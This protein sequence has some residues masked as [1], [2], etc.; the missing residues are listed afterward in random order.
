MTRLIIFDLDGTLLDTIAD[1]GEACNYA[2]RQHGFPTHDGAKYPKMVGN[3]VNKLLERALPEGHKDMETVLDLKTD[4]IAY[5]NDH[6]RVHTHP[7]PGIPELLAE[8][9]RRDILLAVASNKYQEA[10]Q[11]LIRHYFGDGFFDV[12]LG[13]RQG[14]ERKPDPQIV[15]DIFAALEGRGITTE[16][17]LYV[18]DSDVDMQTAKNAHL[19]SVGCTW[20]FCTREKLQE[21]QP[22][23]LV[24]EPSEITK[25]LQ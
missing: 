20:G 24:D 12:V 1:L 21:N 17:T 3:G 7:Y 25:L 2:L 23:H 8:A 13:E 14:V 16:E 15:H 9:K 6:N 10:T 19:T 11:A 22:D 18:G 5:Y 4:F